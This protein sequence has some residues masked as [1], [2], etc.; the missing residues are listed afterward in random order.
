MLP[1]EDIKRRPKSASE[2]IH[3]AP[4]KLAEL[5][6]AALST[7]SRQSAR[8]ELHSLAL[9]EDEAPGE[10]RGASWAVNAL[11][12]TRVRRSAAH[13]TRWASWSPLLKR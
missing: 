7:R 4:T 8:V 12:A 10:R 6:N 3:N 1:G 2:T 9:R 13:G 11:M 5:G